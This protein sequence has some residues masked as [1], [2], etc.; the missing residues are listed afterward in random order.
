MFVSQHKSNIDIK[1]YPS[2]DV[3]ISQ[4]YISEINPESYL[5]SDFLLSSDTISNTQW[6][7]ASVDLTICNQNHVQS[8]RLE[9]KSF[10][11]QPVSGDTYCYNLSGS[12]FNGGFYQGYY[13]AEGYD[14][15]VL[16]NRYISGVTFEFVINNQDFDNDCEI[17]R[18]NDVYTQNEGFLF[19]YGLK[20]ENPYCSRLYSG[21]SCENIPYQLDY[22]DVTVYP[23][24]EQNPFLYYTEDNVCNESISY[25]YEYPDCCDSIAQNAFGVRITD[26]GKINVRFLDYSGSCVS[27]YTQ[28]DMIIKDYTT[29]QAHIEKNKKHHFVLKFQNISYDNEC[30]LYRNRGIMELSIWV[31]GNLIFCENVPELYAYALD[32]HKSVQIGIPYNISIG[33]GTLGNIENDAPI[34]DYNE[35]GCT[36]SFCFGENHGGL[37]GYKIKGSEVVYFDQPINDNIKQ[38]LE[39]IFSGDVEYYLEGKDCKVYKGK[40][41][42]NE[43]IEKLFFENFEVPLKLEQCYKIISHDPCD[44][45]ERYFAGSF[46]GEIDLFKIYNK[47]LNVQQIK[48]IASE[49]VEMFSKCC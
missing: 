36:H 18:L 22:E 5:I 8:G 3:N 38:I 47:A 49:H 32:L 17:P 30:D 34:K 45:L 43:V 31:D 11:I 48:T 10:I 25:T 46:I 40:I 35:T 29:D 9:N 28:D 16:P 42:N 23:W 14:Y 44:I 24:E 6:M 26:E 19:Y 37:I 2:I 4:E 39:D 27:G 33:G 13:K 21:V 12:T 1:L 7:G 20:Q 15:Q 41:D